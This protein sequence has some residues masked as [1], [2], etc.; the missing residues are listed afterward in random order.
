MRSR[1]GDAEDAG[2]FF[3]FHD[4]KTLSGHYQPHNNSMTVSATLGQY[5]C[6][7]FIFIAISIIVIF[8]IFKIVN[9]LEPG[10]GGWR[11]D[12]WRSSHHC[13]WGKG[14]VNGDGDG[15]DNDDI[16]TMMIILLLMSSKQNAV[17]DQCSYR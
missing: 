15:D 13:C 12:G 1:H 6:M 7:I 11:L 9:I 4:S 5:F 16:A 10:R 2:L 3:C 17:P 14:G 8:I